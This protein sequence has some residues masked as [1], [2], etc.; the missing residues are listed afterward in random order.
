M[1]GEYKVQVRDPAGDLQTVYEA[2]RYLEMRHIINTPDYAKMIVDGTNV[3]E[4]FEDGTVIEVLRKVP[5]YEPSAVPETRRRDNGWYVEWDGL[6]GDET[7]ATYPNGDEAFTIY[8]DGGLDL[9]ERREILYYATTGAS[10]SK[11]IAIPAQ[12]AIYQYIE[13]NC[14]ASATTANGRFIDGTIV[15][16]N[17]PVNIGA[18]PNWSG[19]R[20]YRNVLE[21]IQEIANVAEIDFDI[22]SLGNG[23]WQ[24]ETYVDQLGEDRTATGLDGI[25][26]LNAAGNAPVIFSIE[27]HNVA[28]VT[29]S[30]KRRA[31][32]NV[33]ATLGKGQYGSRAYGL[34]T[35]SATIDADRLTQR[36]VSRNANT[37]DDPAELLE[38]ATEWGTRLQPTEDFTF[39]PLRGAQNTIYGV[40][41]WWGDKITSRYQPLSLELDK[42]LVG[43]T[44]VVDRNGEQFRD[45]NFQ[46]IPRR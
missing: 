11:K 20:A 43:V 16:L 18:G 30:T 5:G 44:I 21:V 19:Q 7:H 45:W 35:N 8:A 4:N 27:Q 13:E 14:G 34:Y 2:F 26:G 46:T 24:F 32:A 6:H 15:T 3:A 10:E 41:Y 23:Q 39:V 38:M 29:Y 31:S 25:T 36:E 17:I 1:L 33:V 28:Q 9:A 12:T 22:V 42:R 40:D 37:Q